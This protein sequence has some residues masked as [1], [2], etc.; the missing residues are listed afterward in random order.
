DLVIVRGENHYPQDLE[1]T[2]AKSHPGVRAG[3]G[4][5]FTVEEGSEQKLVIILELERRQRAE[6]AQMI[7]AIRRD[8]AREHELVVDSIVLV[9]AGSIPKTSSGKIQRHVCHDAFLDRSLE[10][11]AEWHRAESDDGKPGEAAEPHRPEAAR[12]PS[13]SNRSRAEVRWQTLEA[14]AEIVLD[15]VRSIGKDRTVG[16]ELDSSIVELGLD[17][18]ERMEIVA[19]L[20]DHFGGRLP[21]Q[22]IAEMYTCR[23]VIDAVQ[24]H[25][26]NGRDTRG[27]SRSVEIPPEDYRFDHY[28]EYIK[29]KQ[30]LEMLESTGLGNPFFKVHD[31]VASN[32]TVIGGREMI[33]FSSYNYVG[34]SGDPVVAAAARAAIDRYGTSVS[35][36]RLVSGETGLH[37]EL[38]RGIADFIGVD[39]AIV[40]VGGHSTNETT[41][42]HLFGPG[43]LILHDALAHNS[44]VQGSILSRAQ[45]RP[46]PHN[47]WRVVDKLLA[48]LRGDYRRVL[49]AIEGVY[50]TD[51]DIPDLPRFIEVSKRHKA[52]LMVDEAHSAGVLGPHGRGIGEHFGVDPQ[53]VDLWMGTLSKSFGSCGGYIAG[54]RAMVEYLKYTAPGFVYSVGISP[55]NAAA[56]LAAIRLLT[57][58]PER[59]ASLRERA[60]LFLALARSRGLNTGLSH[61]S[62]I[63]PVI[64]GDSLHCLRLSQAMFDRG[65][66]VQPILYPAV[67]ERAARLRFFITASHTEEQIRHSIDVTAEE[68]ERIN[69][70][71]LSQPRP[72]QT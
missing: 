69:P 67:E 66:N 3:W 23:E 41:V 58:E 27:A 48:D 8:V 29:L 6:A 46:F 56:A 37:R 36:S 39:D 38:E 32:T 40:F 15:V 16:L 54:C 65:I 68:V 11:V 34:M 19:A 70:K 1:A 60:R 52:F 14:T 31:R 35:A 7:E 62:P 53:D 72:G 13:T 45:R 47:D 51:G 28:P 64:L 22:V 57:G 43:D 26:V 61:D 50:S 30:N 10:V 5:A 4:A 71:Y 20:E 49:V 2:A 59:V 17:S 42:G 12:I 24:K 18:L 33:N 44:I 9:R 25:L 55:A 21:D 63:V